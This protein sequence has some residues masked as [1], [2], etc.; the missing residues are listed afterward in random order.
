MVLRKLILTL[1]VLFSGS[2]YA[3]MANNTWLFNP[4][5]Q[6]MS[7]DDL[8]R[9]Q[10]DC[11]HVADQRTFLQSQLKQI[12]RSQVNNIDRAIIL[13]I[14]SNMEY[15]STE[16]QAVAVGCVHVREDMSSGSANA[17]IC[18]S[19]PAGLATTE[20]PIINRWDPL[21]DMK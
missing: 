10:F 1:A 5:A 12:P 20:K 7:T 19:D 15:C 4:T 3:D 8:N 18:N 2:V 13:S 16:K 17:T 9:F 6:R 14:L 21:V 11:E